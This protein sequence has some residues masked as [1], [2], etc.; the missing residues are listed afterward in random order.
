MIRVQLQRDLKNIF[1]SLSK[2][3]VLVTHDIAEAAYFSS[4]VVLMKHGA[5]VQQGTFREIIEHPAEPFVTQFIRA[6]RSPL[7]IGNAEEP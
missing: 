3:V 4:R 7:D 1:R 5:L 2:T 6:Q